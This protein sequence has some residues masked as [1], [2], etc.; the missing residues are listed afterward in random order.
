MDID[1]ACETM[2]DESKA[3]ANKKT[4]EAEERLDK[5]VVVEAQR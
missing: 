4:A 1:A 3:W 2:Y 5:R